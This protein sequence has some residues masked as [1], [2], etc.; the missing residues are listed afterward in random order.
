MLADFAQE[1]ADRALRLA[2][3]A[4]AEEEGGVLLPEGV[5]PA[6]GADGFARNIPGRRRAA[7][8]GQEAVKLVR[9][10]GYFC[11]LGEVDPGEDLRKSNGRSVVVSGRIT[12]TTGKPGSWLCRTMASS[13]SYC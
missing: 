1:L 7:D 11:D 9:R 13:R 4:A 6:V 3:A 2:R 12:G 5:E 8:G 10:I